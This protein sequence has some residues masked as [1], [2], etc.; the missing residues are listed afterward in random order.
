MFAPTKLE[1]YAY[2]LE[3]FDKQTIKKVVEK[4][5][6]I[7]TAE[8][9]NQVWF[10]KIK[11]LGTEFGFANDMKEF[12]AN[13]QNYVGHYGDVASML[14]VAIT[15]KA[16]TPDLFQICNLLGKEEVI[17]RLKLASEIVSK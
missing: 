17:S 14:R 1:D 15:G 10:A 9:D 5:L 7:Y 13:P 2:N 11:E 4:Y 16:N 3:K 8:T 12:K 6:N